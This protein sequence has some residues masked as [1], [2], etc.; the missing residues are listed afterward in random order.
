M[1]GS[2]SSRAATL[3]VSAILTACATNSNEQASRNASASTPGQQT[4]G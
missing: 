3:A 2:F 4:A 1:N